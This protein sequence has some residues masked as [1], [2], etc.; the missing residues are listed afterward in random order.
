MKKQEDPLRE[1]GRRERQLVEAVV[2]LGEASASQVLQEIPDPP[3]YTSVRTMLQ[4]LVKKGVLQFRDD[5]KRYL[6]KIKASGN[7]VRTAAVKSLL[8]TFFPDNAP[9]AIATILDLVGDRLEE[10]EIDEIQRKI[11]QARNLDGR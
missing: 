4:L 8:A 1:L 2:K 11:D 5:G 6:Y 9:T 7:S 3:T 10:D